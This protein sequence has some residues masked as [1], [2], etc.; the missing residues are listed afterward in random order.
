MGKPRSRP[1]LSLMA[2]GQVDDWGGLPQSHWSYRFHEQVYCALDDAAFADLY[3]EGGRQPVSP[4][5]LVC[6]TI[7]QYIHRVSDR[8]A[9][10]RTIDSRSW[11]IALG[12]EPGWEGFHPTVLCY[13]RKRLLAHGQERRVF[14]VVLERVRALGLLKGH[15]K[16]R[17]DATKLI[18]NVAVLA[19]GDM[20]REALRKVVCSL[21]ELRPKLREQ[22][23]EFKRLYEAYHQEYW[24]GGR[25]DSAQDLR[26]L[27]REAQ[28]VLRLC[29]P[30]PA[31]GKATLAQILEENFS[32]VGAEPEPK[33]A[34][35]LAPDHIATPH[36]PDAEIGKE[37]DELWTGDKV[38][39][40]ETVTADGPGFV[41]DVLVTGPRVP[42]SNMTPAVSERAAEALPAVDTMLSDGGYSSAANTVHAADQGIDL[43][44]PPRQDT[45][46][47]TLS[48]DAFS[49]DFERRV[50]RCPQGHESKSWRVG[51]RLRIKFSRPVCRACPQR[52]ECTTSPTEP[53]VLTLSPHYEQLQQDRA[54]ARTPQ[55]KQLYA[56][57][58]GIEATISELVHRCGLRRSRYRTK[59]KR[60]LHA[61]LSAAALN[62]RRLLRAPAATDGAKQQAEGAFSRLRSALTRALE[63]PRMPR[64]AAE[65]CA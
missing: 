32:F 40:V 60:E 36:E 47:S 4:G 20:I 59:R 35:E 17:V 11:R 58:A 8:E 62:V 27:A 56:Q 65:A 64:S 43:L 38:H 57:R 1:Q 53:R 45:S 31:E 24:L 28:L 50:A 9:V 21:A 54:R 46:H 7:L 63:G 34:A 55:F 61:L 30:Y 29:G 52:A 23:A 22:R 44:S 19:R 5:L 25:H 12:I 14:D 33:P 37:G 49:F 26:A 13:F 10:E 18:A 16:V 42:D 3:E 6:I 51:K 48:A 39:I 15:T 41:V 2:G